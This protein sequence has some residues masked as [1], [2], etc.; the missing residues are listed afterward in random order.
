MQKSSEQTNR[1]NET[2]MTLI[3]Q[4]FQAELPDHILFSWTSAKQNSKMSKD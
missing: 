3:Q 1:M 4:L 2:F